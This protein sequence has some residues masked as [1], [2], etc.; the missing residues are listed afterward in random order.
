MPGAELSSRRSS[1]RSMAFDLGHLKANS[2]A[3]IR[4]PR[5]A[6]QSRFVPEAEIACPMVGED[7]AVADH[8][9]Y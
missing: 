2:D 1:G 5:Y 7:K 3:T 8:V 6:T 4:F 9:C